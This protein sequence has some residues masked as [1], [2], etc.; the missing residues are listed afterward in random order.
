MR[1]NT[2]ELIAITDSDDTENLQPG[3]DFWDEDQ[4]RWFYFQAS[5]KKKAAD[6]GKTY[7]D[8]KINGK[9]YGFDQYGRMVASW[10]TEASVANATQGV[11]SYSNS[12]MYFS[13]P[14][15]GARCTG[16]AR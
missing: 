10:Y 5:G 6:E 16:G 7:V 9:K 3:D 11:A 15:D 13:S 4:E 2:W 12:F 8:K 14:E 1:V